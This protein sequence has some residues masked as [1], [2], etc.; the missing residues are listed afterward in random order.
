MFKIMVGLEFNPGVL[1]LPAAVKS[2]LS[3]FYV[4]LMM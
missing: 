2:A 1:M 4:F 3:V